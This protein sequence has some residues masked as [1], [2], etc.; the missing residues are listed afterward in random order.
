[1]QCCVS[2]FLAFTLLPLWVFCRLCFVLVFSFVFFPYTYLCYLYW[3]KWDLPAAY[4]LLDICLA[5]QQ[6]NDLGRKKE[7]IPVR[8]NA[9]KIWVHWGESLAVS[10][11]QDEWMSMFNSKTWIKQ[12]FSK[13]IFNMSNCI[14]LSLCHVLLHVFFLDPVRGIQFGSFRNSLS[15]LRNGIEGRVL[16][17]FWPPEVLLMTQTM[18]YTKDLWSFDSPGVCILGGGS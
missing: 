15:A 5:T 1:M 12:M 4:G 10:A 2:S 8:K 14:S 16:S 13:L 3:Q 9:W 7:K 18:M 6:W 11:F 17:R